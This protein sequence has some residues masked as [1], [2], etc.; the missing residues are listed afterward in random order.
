MDTII[1][2]GYLCVVT[3]APD[4]PFRQYL[5]RKTRESARGLIVLGAPRYPAGLPLEI[6]IHDRDDEIVAGLS[7]VVSGSE[8]V[9]VLC[10]VS[11]AVRGRGLD[12]HLLRIAEQEAAL[13]GCAA[14][15]AH[16]HEEAS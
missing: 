3:D 6:S 7:A 14:A 13:H 10:W 15:F 12:S 9:V 5:C 1:T 8:I 16:P 4:E 2:G 11:D